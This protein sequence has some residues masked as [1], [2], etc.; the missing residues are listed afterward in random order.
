MKQGTPGF[1]GDRLRLACDIRGLNIERLNGL[2]GIS[3]QMI[4][5]YLKGEKSPAPDTFNI[6]ADKLNFPKEF[7]LREISAENN[8]PV[9]F[10]SMSYT[11]KSERTSSTGRFI[12][13]KEIFLFLEQYIEAVP[14]D[15]PDFGITDPY[16]LTKDDIDSLAH[17]VRKHWN[18]NFGPISNVIQLLENK[19]VIMTGFQMDSEGLDAFSEW[20][21]KTGRPFIILNF[22][23][24]DLKA[25]RIRFNATHEL[26]HLILHKNVD[27]SDLSNSAKFKVLEE[28]AHRFASAFLLPENT[29]SAEVKWS[30]L[31]YFVELKKRWKVS[32]QAIIMRCEQLG[33]ITEQQ[34]TNLFINISKRKWRK[35]EPL[36]D[37]L[38]PEHPVFLYKAFKLIINEVLPIDEL[39]HQ[40]CYSPVDIQEIACL[41]E[42]MLSKK[43]II[44]IME[45]R[46]RRNI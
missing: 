29:F 41:P 5:M 10:R 26:G 30:T 16:T 43:E 14:L 11:T 6:I 12:A 8:K 28:Q 35:E 1:N 46:R 23:R 19:G 44:D 31:D 18:L 39:L 13:L 15:I 45:I 21:H 17:K 37:V 2:I 42:N 9:F 3:R 34:K 7:F 27:K 32:I 25:V 38:I 40:I 20:D 36:D 24:S 22:D 33:I 4:S